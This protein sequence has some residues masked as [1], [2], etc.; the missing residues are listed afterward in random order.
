MKNNELIKVSLMKTLIYLPNVLK[1]KYRVEILNLLK[2]KKKT[3]MELSDKFKYKFHCDNNRY[4]NTYI[5]VKLLEKLG[6]IKTEKYEDTQGKKVYVSLTGKNINDIQYELELKL[7][8]L[9]AVQQ[10]D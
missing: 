2:N 5:N 1:S 4:K 9:L 10:G 6:F 8:K 7:K 3:I